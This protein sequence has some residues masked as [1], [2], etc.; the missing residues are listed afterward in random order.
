[1]YLIKAPGL[2]PQKLHSLGFSSELLA[3]KKTV[4]NFSRANLTF[5]ENYN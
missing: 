1:M 5:L 2:N 3:M 4:K